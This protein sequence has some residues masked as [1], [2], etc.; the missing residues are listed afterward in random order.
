METRPI[1]AAMVQTLTFK[2]D[3]KIKSWTGNGD[4]I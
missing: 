4:E 1:S 2:I 3:R